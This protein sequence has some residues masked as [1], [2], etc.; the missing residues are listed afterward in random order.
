VKNTLPEHPWAITRQKTSRRTRSSRRPRP[1]WRSSVHRSRFFPPFADASKK[2]PRTGRGLR[3]PDGFGVGVSPAV[4]HGNEVVER[5]EENS[6]FTS[7]RQTTLYASAINDV[8]NLDRAEIARGDPHRPAKVLHNC[9][10]CIPS[11]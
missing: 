8:L 5:H 9:R 6:K 2:R 7:R 4:G 11:L 1:R 10:M 3:R